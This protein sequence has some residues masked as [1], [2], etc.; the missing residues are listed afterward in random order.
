MGKRKSITENNDIL[1]LEEV[2]MICPLC[3]RSILSN[4]CV[5]TN[6]NFQIAHIYPCNPTIL[7]LEIL[8][9]VAPPENSEGFNNKIALCK[10]CHWD[11]DQNKT[12]EKYNDLLSVKKQLYAS[13][14]GNR[15]LLA[16]SLEDDIIDLIHKI[17][18]LDDNELTDELRLNY[19][20]IKVDRKIDAKYNILRRQI[21]ENVSLYF[22]VIKKE[23]ESI[24]S[25][26]L[27]KFEQ[28]ATQMKSAY[29]K[30]SETEAN[31]DKIFNHLVTWLKTKTNTEN[32]VC[33]IIISFFVQ[34]C[35]VYDEITK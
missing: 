34:N 11:Y 4:G 8:S 35:E 20:A 30:I 26:G 21:K 2:G 24:D 6:K 10:D 17:S 19:N 23:F 1:H 12:Y 33:Q 13:F 3:K 9:S 28:I 18:R 7:D 15:N 16:I 32:C 29:L 27:R 5:R 22:G 25:Q 14:M 31:K